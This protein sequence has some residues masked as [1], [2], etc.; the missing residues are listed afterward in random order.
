MPR[1]TPCISATGALAGRLPQAAFP[2]PAYAPPGDIGR[3]NSGTSFGADQRL[4]SLIADALWQLPFEHRT[5][6]YKAYYQGWTTARIAADLKMTE[7]AVKSMLH[8]GLH[9]LRLTFQRS[10][11]RGETH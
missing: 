5:V 1:L 6:I 8:D 4:R 3:P 9:A 10:G 11:R 7:A 2:P